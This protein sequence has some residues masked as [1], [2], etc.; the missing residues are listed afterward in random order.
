MKLVSLFTLIT[1]IALNL[2]AAE[3]TKFGSEC[4]LADDINDLKEVGR[5]ISLDH[6]SDTKINSLPTITKQQ[7]IITAKDIAADFGHREPIKTTLDAV[8]VLRSFS[9]GGGL[10]V[11]D[12]LS[13]GV[14]YTSV[15]FYPGG[16]PVGLIFKAGTRHAVASNG[17]ETLTCK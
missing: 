8:S 13:K 5:F 9:E 16:N 7:L 11:Q 6:A 15:Q 12:Y 2:F 3:R 10:S 17:D 1:V 4:G 14:R